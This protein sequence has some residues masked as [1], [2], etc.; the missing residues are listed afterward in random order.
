MDRQGETSLD[1]NEQKKA[2][3]IIIPSVL[4]VV[5]VYCPTDRL[6]NNLYDNRYGGTRFEFP[7]FLIPSSQVSR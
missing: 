7:I 4:T 3:H 1:K 5:N 2:L 6:S